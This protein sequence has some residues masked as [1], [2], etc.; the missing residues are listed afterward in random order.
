MPR[1]AALRRRDKLVK[2]DKPPLSIKEATYGVKAG[3]HAHPGGFGTPNAW[4]VM[5]AARPDRRT[6]S[7]DAY[8]AE[9]QGR[10]VACGELAD[11]YFRMR[12]FAVTDPSGNRIVFGEAIAGE[13]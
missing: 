8:F 6:D 10:H 2:S 11:R 3:V 7:A 5:C 1:G 12:D 13:N 4:Q 9:L